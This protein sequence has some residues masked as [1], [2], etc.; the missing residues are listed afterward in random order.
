MLMTKGLI[1]IFEMGKEGEANPLPL[2]LLPR[3]AVAQSFTLG[4]QL[5]TIDQGI[6]P[7]PCQKLCVRSLL[8]NLSV[9]QDDDP[10]RHASGG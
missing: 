10:I 5:E 2:F 9:I 7:I 1:S 6:F 4:H 8:D 3:R